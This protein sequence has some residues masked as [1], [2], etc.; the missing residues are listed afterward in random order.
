MPDCSGDGA[1]FDY[2]ATAFLPDSFDLKLEFHVDVS[3]SRFRL[4]R[5]EIGGKFSFVSF[6]MSG[7]VSHVKLCVDYVRNKHFLSK[8]SM[9]HYHAFEN[10]EDWKFSITQTIYVN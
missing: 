1:C 9:R 2:F 5:S 4:A 8:I 6:S 3:S 10:D 7:F